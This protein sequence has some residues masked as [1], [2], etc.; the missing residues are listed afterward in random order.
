MPAGVFQGGA[1]MRSPR[2][3]VSGAFRQRLLSAGHSACV[4]ARA[5]A[6]RDPLVKE[7]A[8]PVPC[9]SQLLSV[10]RESE[11]PRNCLSLVA[12]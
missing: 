8:G 5:G 3:H 6:A 12:Y 10:R 11:G 2:A 4:P 7:C 9:C 1:R